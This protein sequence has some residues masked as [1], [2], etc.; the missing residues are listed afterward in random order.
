M[1]LHDYF[2]ADDPTGVPTIWRTA[3]DE[4]VPVLRAS[5]VADQPLWNH[6]VASLTH[7]LPGN[8]A[9]PSNCPACGRGHRYGDDTCHHLPTSSTAEDT[10]TADERDAL[11]KAAFVDG[12]R[13]ADPH[14]DDVFTRLTTPRIAAASAKALRDA[15]A[16]L[17][18][19]NDEPFLKALI[20]INP[21]AANY[22]DW[23]DE[24]LRDLADGVAN[25]I[26]VPNNAPAATA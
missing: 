21:N 6:L 18:R 10:L 25:G 24:T 20:D 2:A 3:K 8:A 5:M 14:I 4:P 19:A 16:L 26:P 12:L 23:V 22:R 9:D 7:P 15:A 11:A 13:A 1:T 17:L